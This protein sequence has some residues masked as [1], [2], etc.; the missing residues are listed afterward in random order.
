MLV[1]SSA[2]IGRCGN[3]LV[4]YC[5]EKLLLVGIDQSMSEERHEIVCHDY[6]VSTCLCRPKVVGDKVV[7]GEVIL[8]FLNPVLRIRSS[9][10]RIVYNL[11][12][13]SEIGDKTAVTVSAEIVPV[14]EKLQLPDLLS[15][16]VG[17]FLYFLSDH[18]DASR[19]V[20]AV[21][22]I[23]RFGYLKPISQLCPYLFVGEAVLDA[24]VETAGY[25]IVHL[26]VFQTV[27]YL[28]RKEAAVHT[29]KSDLLV[30]KS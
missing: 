14:L 22:L 8:Q 2:Q 11:C 7:D 18:Y 26:L 13:Q 17:T 21:R 15:G 20:P 27:K 24:V 16:G 5:L 9:A 4:T 3:Q 10:I 12:R 6:K 19:L 29:D 28:I 30:F 23:C 1:F 25:N